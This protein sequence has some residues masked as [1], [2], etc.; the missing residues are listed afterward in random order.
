M[1][2]LIA[3]PLFVIASVLVYDTFRF[4][5]HY[6]EIET[7]YG[8]IIEKRFIYVYND[9]IKEA[10]NYIFARNKHLPCNGL[11]TVLYKLTNIKK[12]D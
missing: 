8:D 9:P 6:Y 3:L 1:G 10:N 7:S 11:N 4:R 2:F 5:E 12:I